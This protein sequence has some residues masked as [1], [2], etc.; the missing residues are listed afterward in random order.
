[1]HTTKNNH[2]IIGEPQYQIPTALRSLSIK[3]TEVEAQGL[4]RVGRYVGKFAS[5][6]FVNRYRAGDIASRSG[7]SVCVSRR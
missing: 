7:A 2:A 3:W 6:R 1:M 4:G 5:G